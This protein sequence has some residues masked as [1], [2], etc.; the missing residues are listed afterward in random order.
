M[1]SWGQDIETLSEKA[2]NELAEKADL[3][4]EDE[5]YIDALDQFTQLYNYKPS[6]LYYKL[7]M[8]I[9]M[10][11]DPSQKEKAIEILEQVK[12][13]NPE[14]NL[15]N[16]YL[17]KVYLFNYEFDKA[18]NLFNMFLDRAEKDDI[19]QVN[20][21]KQM[22]RNCENAKEMFK[23][24]VTN[25]T[26][27]NIQYPINSQYSEYVPIISADESMMIFTYRGVKS[28]GAENIKKSMGSEEYS[29]DVFI[30][31]KK[32]GDWTEPVSIGENINSDDHDA[33][34]AL[35]AD[36]QTLFIYKSDGGGDI[37][38]STLDGQNWLSPQKLK[39]DVN[40]EGSWEGSCSLS[41]NGKT[42]YF[43]SDRK[44][45]LGGRD[46]YRSNLQAD[47]SWRE[48]EN[49]GAAINTDQN[50]DDP[51]IHSGNKTLYFSSEGHTSIGGYDIFSAVNNGDDSFGSVK[52]LGFPMNTIDDNRFFVLVADGE[53]GYYS[54]AGANSIGEQDIFKINFGK[55]KKPVLALLIGRVY[56]NEKVKGSTIY[57][58]NI[59][60]NNLEGKFVSNKKTGK[61]VMVLAPGSYQLRV[62]F[63][64]GESIIDSL[65]LEGLTTYVDVAKDFKFYNDPKLIEKKGPNLQEII[66]LKF[67]KSENVNNLVVTSK[68]K[69][70]QENEKNNSLQTGASLQN[71][72]TINKNE[73]LFSENINQEINLKKMEVGNTFVFKN[74]MYPV[75]K[76]FLSAESKIL[77]D[78][79]TIIL[80]ENKTIKLKIGS[81]TDNRLSKEFNLKLSEK[82]AQGVVNYLISKG[83]DKE[84]LIAKA[85]GESHPVSSNM[86]KDGRQ[87][88]RRIEFTIIESK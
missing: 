52:N 31:Y 35:S 22:I 70:K 86:Y 45:G 53:T 62:E 50:E 23:D 4:F 75:D 77:L 15:G 17:A 19:I 8:G 78:S 21:A 34:I 48:V 47:G 28:K 63:E 30:S 42:L 44:G 20:L 71:A 36:G 72:L 79:L 2:A 9:C 55:I 40:K 81:H 68:L 38:V 32:N 7:M 37:Y 26:V 84:R 76:Y 25:N 18:I 73:N 29:E 14:Y 49:L 11:Y 27:E 80:K 88:N 66:D 83:I 69:P 39:G 5:N 59:E 51:F 65:T 10:A 82:R 60:N 43:S 67:A 12:N 46:I 61:Y 74:I 85:Y 6:D 33:A 57:L 24:T 41:A 87:K 13:K 58:Y 16:F 54:G 56:F 1:N 3:S 64:S